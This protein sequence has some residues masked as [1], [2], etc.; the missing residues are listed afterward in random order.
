M[1]RAFLFADRLRVNIHGGAHVGVPQQFLLDF[2][3]HAKLPQH[4]AVGVTVMPSAAARSAS[5]ACLQI[6][7][8]A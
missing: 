6:S 4:G 3:I 5:R 2:Q 7:D 1:G 8:S